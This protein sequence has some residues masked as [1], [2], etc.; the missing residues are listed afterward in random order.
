MKANR[1]SSELP[2][3]GDPRPISRP[4]T[5]IEL[6]PSD[7]DI[8]PNPAND[9]ELDEP[10]KDKKWGL[11]HKNSI[12]TINCLCDFIMTFLANPH[13]ILQISH[14]NTFEMKVPK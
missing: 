12:Y 3:R 9:T 7:D 13:F 4:E 8:A 6:E 1:G 10:K 14:A 5:G 11:I 2:R